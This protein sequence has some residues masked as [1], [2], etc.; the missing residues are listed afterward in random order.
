MEQ[1]SWP[2]PGTMGPIFSEYLFV[3]FFARSGEKP[4]DGRY[5]PP[6][7]FQEM[8]MQL[9]YNIAPEQKLIKKGRNF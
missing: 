3:R 6:P 4:K 7:K 5:W 2:P 9:R 1:M 8:L